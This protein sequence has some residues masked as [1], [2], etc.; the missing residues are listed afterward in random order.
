MTFTPLSVATPTPTSTPTGSPSKTPW[1]RS[2]HSSS[3]HRPRR[4]PRT[5]DGPLRPPHPSR[6]GAAVD[7]GDALDANAEVYDFLRTVCAKFGIGFWG[8]GSGII[9]QVVLEHYAFPGGMMIGTDS[10]TPNAGGLGMLSIGV[11]G[12]DAIDVMTGSPFNLRWPQLIGVRLTGS[13]SGWSS[14]KDVILKV[15][16]ALTV[17]GGTGAV[18]EYFGPGHRPSAPRAKPPSATWG[19]RSAP[20]PRCSPS[21][22]RRRPICRAT[23]GAHLADLASAVAGDLRADDEVL[24]DPEQF[25]D[26]VI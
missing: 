17:T 2:S 21:T 5:D 7:L 22:R 4:G 1:P 10:H 20:P 19:P 16:E 24:T 18:I 25:F 15:A 9:H 26:R 13:L 11:G 6:A 14:P 12:G 8:P 23:D 3:G